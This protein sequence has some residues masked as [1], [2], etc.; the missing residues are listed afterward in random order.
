MSRL[1]HRGT[2]TGLA[3]SGTTPLADTPATHVPA[4]TPRPWRRALRLGA[5]ALL[6]IAA[7]IGGTW[8]MQIGRYLQATDNATVQGDIAV[9]SPRVEGHVAAILVADNARVSADQP[10]IRLDDRDWRARLAEAQAQV[11]S[12]AAAVTTADRQI[13]Q[14]DAVIAQMQAAIAYARAEAV[15]ARADQGRAGSL[16][17]GGWTSRQAVDKAE[18]DLRKAD[19]GVVQ[20]EASLAAAR[21]QKTVLAAGAQQA[22]AVLARMQA[23]AEVAQID[24]D[25]T[26]IRAPFDGVVGN[27]AAQ[28]GQYVRPGQNLIAVAPARAGLYVVANF[29]ETQL[30]RMRTGQPVEIAVDALGGAVLH[31]RLDSIAPATGATF[32]VLPPDNAT[33]NF[34]KIVQRVPVRIRLEPNQEGAQLLRPGLS[35][36]VTVDTRP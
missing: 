10:L 26:V 8:H 16:V 23:A 36:R 28:L 27:R 34:T 32:S 5:L 35:V 33:G 22:R 15:R 1:E 13:D 21:A 19:A 3:P 25:N 2:T 4:T 18:A 31:G 24:L 11:S 9:L 17:A 30:A 14:Q 6:L 29:K 7:L 20:A 12:A